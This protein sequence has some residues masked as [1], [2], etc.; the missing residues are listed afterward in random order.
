[1]GVKPVL[2]DRFCRFVASLVKRLGEIGEGISSVNWETEGEED[3]RIFE[4]RPISS[5]DIV[6][7]NGLP[8]FVAEGAWKDNRSPV[9]SSSFTRSIMAG[10]DRV[11]GIWVFS[12]FQQLAWLD[13]ERLEEFEVTMLPESVLRF[14]EGR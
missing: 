10:G 13:T 6:G 1:M 4:R 14:F 2:R 8:N 12:D 11:R 7:V 5:D 3:R 9:S